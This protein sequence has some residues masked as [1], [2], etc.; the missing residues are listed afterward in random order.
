MGAMRLNFVFF[1]INRTIKLRE[2]ISFSAYV[3]D[4]AGRVGRGG[5]GLHCRYFS[6]ASSS[7][8]KSDSVFDN[9]ADRAHLAHS[10]RNQYGSGGTAKSLA[11]VSRSFLLSSCRA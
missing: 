2:P 9:N 6:P 5:H 10:A 11:A 1:G 8:I 4:G 7:S 3:V